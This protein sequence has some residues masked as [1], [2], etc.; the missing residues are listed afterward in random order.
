[1]TEPDWVHE[2][3]ECGNLAW[4]DISRY[5]ARAAAAIHENSDVPVTVGMSFPKYHSDGFPSDTNPKTYEGDK[6][7]DAFLQKI[8]PNKN[9]YLDFLSPH[10]Y[11][12]V[13]EH[14]GAPYTAKPHGSRSDG[15]WGLTPGKPAVLAE[16]PASG[17][18]GSTTTQD[19]QNAFDNGWQGVLPWTSNR[20]D[21][22][23]GFED[24]S[25]G[26]LYMLEK[27]REVIFPWE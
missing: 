11:D 2:G 27:Y 16:C 21:G 18:R 26:T 24:F 25:P 3:K 7:S 8:Y 15:G 6:V 12:W 20:V 9:A 22:C 10:Y 13:G 4:E 14:Y 1:M 23:G 17:S 19:F 5:F